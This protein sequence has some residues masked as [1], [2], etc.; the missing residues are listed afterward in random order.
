MADKDYLTERIKYFSDL[1]KL[2]CVFVVA[3]GSGT[4][5]SLFGE[6]SPLRTLLAVAG[7]GL[8]LIL[9]IACGCITREW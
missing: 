5:S 6:F 1:L 9:V 8:I 4:I 2:S 7:T 3:I